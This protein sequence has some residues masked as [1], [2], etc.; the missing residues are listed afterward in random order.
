MRWIAWLLVS[1]SC[2]AGSGGLLPEVKVGTSVREVEVKC[3][4]KGIPQARG[5]IYLVGTVKEVAAEVDRQP[6]QTRLSESCTLQVESA[7][8]YDYE[9]LRHVAGIR[10]AVLKAAYEE[11]PYMPAGDDW[12]CLWHYTKGQRVLAILRLFEGALCCDMEEMLVLDERTATLPEVLRRTELDDSRFTAS[13]LTVLMGAG[14]LFDLKLVRA[15]KALERMREQESVA[16]NQLVA[17]CVVLFFAV[18]LCADHLRRAQVAPQN[19]T[20]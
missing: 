4:P 3:S 15:G 7:F 1:T 20:T 2:M 5:C 9:D 11:S 18:I 12:G 10:T 19:P 14:F 17:V 13:D 16:L 8:G 6:Q